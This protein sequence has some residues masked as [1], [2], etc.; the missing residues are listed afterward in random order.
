MTTR[1]DEINIRP[2]KHY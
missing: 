2:T 1:A